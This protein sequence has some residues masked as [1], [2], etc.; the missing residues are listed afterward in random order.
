M[1]HL[2][3]SGLG[4]AVSDFF[5]TL[6]GTDGSALHENLI[7]FPGLMV[8]TTD[9]AVVVLVLQRLAVEDILTM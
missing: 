4:N 2:A 7:Y 3:L 5:D 6:L 9:G 8:T 1:G